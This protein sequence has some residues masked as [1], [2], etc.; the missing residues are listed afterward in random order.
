ML[1][2]PRYPLDR[3]AE[4]VDDKAAPA[5]TTL[6]ALAT[7]AGAPVIAAVTMSRLHRTAPSPGRRRVA[8]RPCVGSVLVLRKRAAALAR[9]DQ[10]SDAAGREA[11]C[12]MLGRYIYHL[13]LA[14]EAVGLSSEHFCR[15]AATVTD[16][17]PTAW[18]NAADPAAGRG[19]A[20][21]QRSARHPRAVRRS[22][23]GVAGSGNDVHAAADTGLRP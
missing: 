12:D 17:P 13:G 21:P 8:G 16:L 23:V 10:A 7:A 15:A 6:S 19:R 4:I 22:R 20:P 1:V 9:D 2:A 11:Q 5:Y 14:E 18:R 3:S